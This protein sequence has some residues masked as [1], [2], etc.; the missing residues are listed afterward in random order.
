MGRQG[1]EGRSSDARVKELVLKS[2]AA[3]FNR[4]GYTATTVREI[5]AAVG[6]SKPVLY[7]Y[8]GSK[9][10]IFFELMRE[11]FRKF[12]AVLEESRNAEGA[13]E[14]GSTTFSAQLSP[15]S[16]STSRR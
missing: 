1:K 15:S 5:V 13:P 2:A 12:E 11:P 14:R 8:F 4:K 16:W 7:Y 9:E 3:L 6:V 10:G